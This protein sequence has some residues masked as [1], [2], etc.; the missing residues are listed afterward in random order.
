[1][2]SRFHFIPNF[3]A[4]SVLL[5]A[6]LTVGTALATQ[7]QVSEPVV[8]PARTV[9]ST[10]DIDAAFNRADVNG[11]GKLDRAEAARFPVIEQRF[12]QIDSDRDQAVSRE[13]FAAAIKT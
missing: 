10:Q 4:R 11:D 5:L 2:A 6:A 9:T 1:M 13:E 8:T 3:D 12:D 7:A